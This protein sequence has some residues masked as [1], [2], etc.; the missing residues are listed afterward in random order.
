MSTSSTPGAP[1]AARVARATES[2]RANSALIDSECPVNTGTRTQVP[3]TSRSG[4]PRI[5]RD[6]LRSFCSS[7]VSNAPSSTSEP[8][9][10]STLNAIGRANFTGSGKVDRRAVV[11]QAGRAVE[12]LAHLLVE[13]VDAGQPGARHRLVGRR[14]SAGSG[15]PRGA[16]ASST[17]IAAIVVQFGLAMMPLRA[18]ATSAPLTSATTSG[19][20]GSI[21][22]ADELSITVA[23]AAA[24]V[25]ASSR[26][27]APP[28]ENSAMS[29]PDGSARGGVLDPDVDAVPRQE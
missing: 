3:D 28:A 12:G 19:T 16:A 24:N 21:R 13:L 6:S 1:P 20:S 14:R 29:S 11:R 26:D 22:Q 10:G 9:S 27:P 25:G 5:L 7:S 8:A 4:M 15:R 23:P 2:G 18:F 17:G